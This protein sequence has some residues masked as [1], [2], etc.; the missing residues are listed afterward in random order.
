[1]KK[2]LLRS[3]ATQHPPL[4]GAALADATGSPAADAFAS[5][6]SPAIAG[7]EGG[8]GGDS[9][10]HGGM[11]GVEMANNHMDIGEESDYLDEID[12]IAFQAQ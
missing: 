9:R 6:Q 1:M 2:G 8:R 11:G 3:S 10:R 7:R 12:R 5:G 4:C